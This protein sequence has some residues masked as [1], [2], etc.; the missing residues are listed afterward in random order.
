[1]DP[2]ESEVGALAHRQRAAVVEAERPRGMAGHAGERLLGG[3]P[4]QVA[5]QIQDRQQRGD[6]RGAGIAVGRKGHRHA[7]SAE[8][9]DRWLVSFAQHVEGAGQQHGHRSRRRHG[10]DARFARVLE[11][12]GRQGAK[13]R[14]ESRAAEIR[15]LVGMQLDRQA[16]RPGGLEHPRHLVGRERDA[17][18]ERVD[19]VGEPAPGDLRQHLGAHQVEVARAVGRVFLG[20]SVRA[21]KRGA[22]VRPGASHPGA[23]PPRAS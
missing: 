14:R 5:G 2:P 7:V 10:P 20:Q 22:D 3:Q 8:L 1:M 15:E 18:A 11:V 9:L 13:A 23:A 16:K 21:E 4:E 17:L 19:R 6:R 12:I